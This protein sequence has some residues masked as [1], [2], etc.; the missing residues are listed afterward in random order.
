MFK[1]ILNNL[2]L[3]CDIIVLFLIVLFIFILQEYFTFPF[4]IK[5]NELVNAI[6][7]KIK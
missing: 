5:Q 2:S 1:N 7:N 3:H 4:S 6:S